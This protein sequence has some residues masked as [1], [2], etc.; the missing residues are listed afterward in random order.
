MLFH[1]SAKQ[2]VNFRDILLVVY[3]EA[4]K[5]DFKETDTNTMKE[6]LK[7]VQKRVES[8][9][10]NMDKIQVKQIELLCGDLQKF[11]SQMS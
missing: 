5:A 1:S 4:T 2:I 10:H 9:N 3:R 8:Y 11:I 6:I 7:L